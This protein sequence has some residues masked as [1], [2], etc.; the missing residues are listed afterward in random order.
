MPHAVLSLPAYGPVAL[1][2]L[3]RAAADAGVEATRLLFMPPV[4]RARSLA[5]VQ[6]ADLF[7]DS[8]RF[9]A[10]YGLVDALRVGVPAVSCAGQNMA[11]RLGGSILRAAGL[12]DLVL[13]SPAAFVDT[14][15][16]LGKDAV[17]L[18]NLRARLAAQR[19]SA[20]LFDPQ[21]R[22]R[23]WEAAWATMVERQQAGL[24]PLAFDVPEQAPT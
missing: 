7:V 22:V 1:G 13:D 18:R 10:N 8:L 23:E 16:A 19:S 4:P 5:L 24:P 3:A 11:S 15:V 17:A 12:G 2:N 21:A 9:N 6:L 14:V 20:P